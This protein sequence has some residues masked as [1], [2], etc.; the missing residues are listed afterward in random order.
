[1]TKR[2]ILA[3]KPSVARDI[4]RVLNINKKNNGYLESDKYVITWALGHL[5]TLADP[6]DY[7][8]DYSNWKLEDLP[9][10]PHK[11]KLIPIKNTRKQFNTVKTLLNR[12]DVN[13]IIIAT[14]AGREGELVARWIIEM[15][16]VD[17]PIK[18]LW[19]SSVTDKAIRDGFNRLKKGEDYLNLFYSAKSRAEADWIVGINA[20]RALT[21]KHNTPLSC[22]R[23][24]TPTLNMVKMRED[25]IAKFVPKKYYGIKI[26]AGNLEFDYIDAKGSKN[27][28]NKEYVDKIIKE[29]QSSALEI[30]SI[31]SKVKKTYPSSLYNLT[32]LQRDANTKFGYSAK[33]TLNIMQNLYERHKVLSYPRTDSSFLTSDIVPTFEERL[34]GM[35]TGKYREYIKALIKKNYSTKMPIINNA[36]VGDHHAIIPTEE[37]LRIEELSDK[38]VKIYDLVANRFLE[39]LMDPFIYEEV[40]ITGNINN[41]LMK[42]KVQKTIN[43]GYKVIDA[44][45]S[46]D[47]SIDNTIKTSI[48]DQLKINN[49]KII[50][51]QTK[52]PEYFSEGSL[53]MAMENPNKFMD[54]DNAKYKKILSTSGGIGTV[55]TRADI[56]EKLYNTDLIEKNNQK[57]RTTSKGRQLL[58]LVP[59]IIKSPE[60]TAK[61]E[62]KLINIQNGTLKDQ[63]FLKEIKD[64]SKKVINEIENSEYEFRHDNMTRQKCP[65]CD[66]YLLKVNRKDREMLVCSNRE[67]K[68][69]K[70]ISQVTNSRC[71]V[72]HKKLILVGEGD[73]RTFTCQCGHRESYFAFNKRKEKEKSAMNKGEVK[74]Y[75]QK[76]EKNKDEVVNTS[77]ADALKNLKF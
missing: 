33:E 35:N 44:K 1:M 56:I 38:E 13:E 7:R 63:V 36:K 39:N 40:E 43:L 62:E 14:D 55:A 26:K 46:N 10:I 16:K 51:N 59:E 6:E 64:F 8:K 31:Q 54:S 57:I 48:G 11:M 19:I 53:L 65:E 41:H 61:W 50:E 47:S 32:T 71:P 20:T 45:N 72:C 75:L 77:L 76:Q 29:I 49:I 28:F 27:F 3:E 67:C 42:T 34:K 15:S 58:Q 24:Q 69:R 52:S 68:Y 37:T 17:K 18:R 5:V 74:K 4:A 9:I 22:G 12:K 60:L 73:K 23:V 30:K 2:I 66:S 25:E 21:V 70:T